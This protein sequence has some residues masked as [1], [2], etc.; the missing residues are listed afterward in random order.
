MQQLRSLQ[1]WAGFDLLARGGDELMFDEI[2]WGKN[3]ANRTPPN[4]FMHLCDLLWTTVVA[5]NHALV[6][7]NHTHT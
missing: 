5:N 2:P 7:Q 6:P 3:G 4:A 1:G